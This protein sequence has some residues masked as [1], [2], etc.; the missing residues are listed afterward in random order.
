M[1]ALS[2]YKV[3]VGM[4]TDATVYHGEKPQLPHPLDKAGA[5]QLAAHLGADLTSLIPEISKCTVTVAA[6][7]YDQTQVLRPGFPLFAA[8][9]KIAESSS[10]ADGFRPKLLS[11][12]AS[13]GQMPDP[14][15]QP[16][17]DIP[18][19]VLQ[20]VP[21]LISGEEK[22]VRKLGEEMEH[23]FLEQGQ[24]SANA[25]IWLQQAWNIK[26]IHGRFMTLVDLTAMLHLQLESFNFKPLWELVE[27]ALFQPGETL[28]IQTPEGN[29][30]CYK[31]GVIHSPFFSFDQFASDGPG[32]NTES[33][34]HQLAKCYADW[35]RVQRQYLMTLRSHGLDVLQ[36]LPGKPD[37]PVTERFLVEVKPEPVPGGGISITE[38]NAGELGTVA[39]TAIRDDRQFNY[40][41]LTPAGLN[42]I[43]ALLRDLLGSNAELS[44]PGFICYNEQSRSLTH[45]IDI[46]R[47]RT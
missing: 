37:E 5:E 4:E 17:L 15:L 6:G 46:G 38:H 20:L 9:Q 29:R 47:L 12:G 11:I 39:I 21:I 13:S 31:N 3:L 33:A 40:Y 23:R 32:S 34:K 45:D 14:A 43:H 35:T 24:L 41:P 10:Q 2:H 42:D 8:L 36:H 26:I 28:D 27:C 18:P 25:G 22:L 1:T 19:S 16:D 30:F 44:F 7:L